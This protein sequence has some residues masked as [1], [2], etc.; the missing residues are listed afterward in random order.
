MLKS[1]IVL[2]LRLFARLIAHRGSTTTNNIDREAAGSAVR[3]CAAPSD[4]KKAR[5]EVLYLQSSH[6]LVPLPGGST[7][8]AT[9]L[10][11]L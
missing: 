10:R 11:T 4:R 6:C 3:H 1:R 9:V 2:A 8:Y 5:A 7:G